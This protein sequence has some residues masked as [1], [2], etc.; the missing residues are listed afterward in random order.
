MAPF[1][2]GLSQLNL[3]I[4]AVKPK[5]GKG[6]AELLRLFEVGCCERKKG[7]VHS[8]IVVGRPVFGICHGCREG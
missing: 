8:C 1:G 2:S 7:I 3:N 6:V 4:L 5:L